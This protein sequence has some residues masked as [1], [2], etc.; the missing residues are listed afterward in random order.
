MLVS[1]QHGLQGERGIKSTAESICGVFGVHESS[2]VKR[3]T[4]G[5][6]ELPQ[7]EKILPATL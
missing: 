7:R 5:L 6:P 2:V 1:I 3:T 4:T